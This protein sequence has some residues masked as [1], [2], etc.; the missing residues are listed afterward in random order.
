LPQ[1]VQSTAHALHGDQVSRMHLGDVL[2]L[3]GNV[4][5][6]PAHGDLAHSCLGSRMSHKYNRDLLGFWIS[7][8]Y[9]LHLRP[10]VTIL[11]HEPLDVLQ[12]L[13]QPVVAEKL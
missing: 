2:D 12:S 5:R 8:F 7:P 9:S 11:L 13:C 1:P 4:A 10:V 3:R 6:V